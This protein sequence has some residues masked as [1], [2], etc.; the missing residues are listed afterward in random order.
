MRNGISS[1]EAIALDPF[2]IE[3][4]LDLGLPLPC[5]KITHEPINCY[6]AI[7]LDPIMSLPSSKMIYQ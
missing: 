4:Y 1:E 3:A 5:V 2:A 7:R 6:G